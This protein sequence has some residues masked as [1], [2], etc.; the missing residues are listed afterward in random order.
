MVIDTDYWGLLV[1][2]GYLRLAM[3]GFAHQLVSPPHWCCS[4]K[5]AAG[6]GSF[7]GKL[8]VW[9]TAG[10]ARQKMR[11]KKRPWRGLALA[12]PGR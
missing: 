5:T 2:L 3:S 7:R 10:V 8:A 12:P 1:F 6:D 4:D 9:R 11:V